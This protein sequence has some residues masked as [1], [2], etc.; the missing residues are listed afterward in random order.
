L[1]HQPRP[2]SQFYKLR[3]LTRQCSFAYNEY[4]R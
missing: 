2:P 1:A 3:I 4:K